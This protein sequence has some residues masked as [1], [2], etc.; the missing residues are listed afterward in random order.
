MLYRVD[1]PLRRRAS[2][3][4]LYLQ[5]HVVGQG[6]DA[7]RASPARGGTAARAARQRPGL[8]RADQ[9]RDRARA[10]AASSGARASRRSGRRRST[11]PLSARER[12]LRR[13][14]HRPADGR[15]GRRHARPEPG[16]ARARRALPPLHVPPG[17]GV[18]IVFDVSPLSHPRTGVG[19]YLRGS[20]RGLAEAAGRTTRSSRSRRRARRGQAA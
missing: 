15:P 3:R 4:G 11:L 6:R 7:T 9:T 10:A 13:R 18:R 16:H 8:F 17:R 5:R 2:S 19:N 1:G 14:L 20:L 12:A